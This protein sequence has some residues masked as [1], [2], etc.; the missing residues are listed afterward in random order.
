MIANKMYNRNTKPVIAPIFRLFL[1]E[2][3]NAAEQT[4]PKE[5]V[6][7]GFKPLVNISETETSYDIEMAIP[8]FEKNNVSISIE[9]DT[10]KIS[11][12]REIK[13]Y[14]TNHKSEYRHKSFD[15]TFNLGKEIDTE[16]VSA[17][18]ENGILTILLNKKEEAKPRKIEIEK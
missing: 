8:G 16:N 15:R 18:F 2:L 6:Q 1:N 9:N 7:K 3:N 4:N 11:G 17:K 13:E 12:T 10:L 14:K 5:M